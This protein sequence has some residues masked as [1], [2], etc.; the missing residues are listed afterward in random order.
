VLDNLP[1]ANAHTLVGRQF[2]PNLI[3]GP[4]HDGLVVVFLLA[5]VMSLIAA[6][7]CLIRNKRTETDGDTD[8]QL[9]DALP[10]DARS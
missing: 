3:S 8:A 9:A 2:F 10:A 4:F 1:A 5:I 6:G 7:A